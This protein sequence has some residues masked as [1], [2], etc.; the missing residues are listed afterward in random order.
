MFGDLFPGLGGDD[1]GSGRLGSGANPKL[2]QGSD[3]EAL[4]KHASLPG[5]VSREEVLRSAKDS[6]QAQAAALLLAKYSRNTIATA[7][8]ALQ[9]YQT[10]ANH[11]SQML[12]IEEQWQKTTGRHLQSIAKFD[13]GIA[14]NAAQLSG[15][16]TELQ[17]ATSIL[18]F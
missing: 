7:N 9:N 1:R 2:I 14:E 3:S 18:G 12:R 4:R 8:A 10:R 15:F 17:H 5:S 13:L 16:E 11:S 6:G